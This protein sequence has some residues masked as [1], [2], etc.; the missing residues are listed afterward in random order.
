MLKLI[1]KGA[2]S[3]RRGVLY[4]F[5]EL[6]LGP[7]AWYRLG[8]EEVVVDIADLV[9]RVTVHHLRVGGEVRTRLQDGDTLLHAVAG[10][11]QVDVLA[12]GQ[13]ALLQVERQLSLRL[14]QRRSEHQLGLLDVGV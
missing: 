13:R 2:R 8:R 6:P 7:V 5:R 14:E 11:A 4:Y 3:K 1:P 12:N 9:E 10:L